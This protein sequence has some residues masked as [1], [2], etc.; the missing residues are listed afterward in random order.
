MTSTDAVS[1][2]VRFDGHQ[3]PGAQVA[4]RKRGRLGRR[5]FALFDI[6]ILMKGHVGGGSTSDGF[7]ASVMWLSNMPFHEFHHGKASVGPR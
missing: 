6:V 7:R 2:T 4:P 3:K 1:H 5:S